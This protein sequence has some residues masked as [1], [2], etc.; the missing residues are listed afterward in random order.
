M[1]TLL[2]VVVMLLGVAA[3]VV[4]GQATAE[5]GAN[6]LAGEDPLAPA[7]E[8]AA[9]RGAAGRGAAGG[10][11]AGARRGGPECGGL[12]LASLEEGGQQRAGRKSSPTRPRQ[13]GA[14]APPPSPRAAAALAGHLPK[15]VALGALAAGVDAEVDGLRAPA[16]RTSSTASS[17]RLA[18]AVDAGGDGDALRGVDAPVDEA[19]VA[20]EEEGEEE[21]GEEEEVLDE[22]TPRPGKRLLASRVRASDDDDDDDDD[23]GGDS[24]GGGGG[25]SGGEGEGEDGAKQR[26]RPGFGPRWRKR[27][28]DRAGSGAGLGL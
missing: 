2:A 20:E 22:G 7:A 5:E 28:Y 10:G 8:G 12:E 4:G 13:G 18:A 26:S 17:R 16:S 3:V 27:G 9:G 15:E 19:S 25:G 6:Q 23:D 1:L 11:A 24:G 14:A 21:E